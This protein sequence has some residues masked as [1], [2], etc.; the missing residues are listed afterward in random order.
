MKIVLLIVC[1]SFYTAFGQ[2]KTASKTPQ[3]DIKRGLIAYYNADNQAN[4]VSPSGLNGSLM[5]G[6]QIQNGRCDFASF[7]FDGEDD[8]IDCGKSSVLNN[9]NEG[10]TVSAWIHPKSYSFVGLAMITGRWAFDNKKD[11]F[12]LFVNAEGKAVFVVATQ[13]TDE[14]GIFSHA[15]LP[16]NDWTHVVGTWKPDGTLNLY[17]NG[18]QDNTGKQRGKGFNKLSDVTLKIGRQ[19]VG[20]NRSF[21]GFLDDIRLYNRALTPAEATMLYNMEFSICNQLII[22]GNVLSTKNNTPVNGAEIVAE[23]LETGQEVVRFNT[24]ETNQ[25]KFKLPIGAEYALYAVK[26]NYLSLNENIQTEGLQPLTV[27]RKNLYLVPLEVGEKLRLNN[28]FFDFDKATLRPRSKYELNRLVKVFTRY[29]NLKIE[30]AGHTDNKG[31]DDYN[32]RLSQQRADA[33]KAYLVSQKVSATKVIAK[34]YGESQPVATNDT[35]E[36]RQLNRRV[37]VVILQK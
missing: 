20:K 10:L 2:T 34:G 4:D 7:Y 31:S 17:I 36:G 8:Y 11:Q 30:V 37:E 19:V 3:P 32:K 25:F 24:Q 15:N 27:L 6:A 16:I 1:L 14:E 21:K 5:Q 28:I 33:V 22:E 13:G 18:K 9:F 26:E 35:D 29:P 12:G 23:N